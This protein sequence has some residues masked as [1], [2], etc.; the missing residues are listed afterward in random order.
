MQEA[1]VP[2][3]AAMLQQDW[4][5]ELARNGL[6]FVAPRPAEE[7]SEGEESTEWHTTAWKMD[8][9]HEELSW[10]AIAAPPFQRRAIARC[11]M[12]VR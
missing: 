11:P 12:S 8:L 7:G 1:D 10:E 3:L 4:E 6:S 5:G 2:K 9:T